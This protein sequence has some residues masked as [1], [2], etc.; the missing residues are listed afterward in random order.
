[1]SRVFTKAASNTVILFVIFLFASISSAQE[2]GSIAGRVLDGTT[3]N[4]LP[5]V[6]IVV[7]G[8]SLST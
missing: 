1:M 4:A 5:G 6:S 2:N 7:E 8:T 3:G